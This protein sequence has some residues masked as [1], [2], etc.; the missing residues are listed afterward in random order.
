MI[1]NSELI[2]DYQ[3]RSNEIQLDEVDRTILRELTLDGRLPNNVLAQRVGLAPSTCLGRVRAL[4]RAGVIRG[5]H[6][7]I[8]LRALGLHVFALISINVHAQ[9]RSRML[10]LAGR[11]RA[12]PQVLEVYVLGGDR[13]L[14][15]HVA[16]PTAEALRDFV[17]AH[18]GSHEAFVNTQTT[19]I[20]DHL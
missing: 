17:S 13:D 18:L 10:D 2:Q 19:L 3:H 14:M 8:D 20:F 1:H 12:L 4:R 16:C 11:L 7:D 15:I 6:A 9:A 5:Y